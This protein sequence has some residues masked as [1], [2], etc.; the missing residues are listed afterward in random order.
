MI[1]TVHLACFNGCGKRDFAR[2]WAQIC[3]PKTDGI[4]VSKRER[5]RERYIYIYIYLYIE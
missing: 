2:L 5:E 1:D 3:G 4:L